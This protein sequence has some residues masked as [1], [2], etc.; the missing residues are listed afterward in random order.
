MNQLR[1]ALTILDEKCLVSSTQ[2]CART[3]IFNYR[4]SEFMQHTSPTQRVA[5]IVSQNYY[6]QYPRGSR[7]AVLRIEN[8]TL[9][10]KIAKIHFKNHEFDAAS[11]SIEQVEAFESNRSFLFLWCYSKYMVVSCL[12]DHG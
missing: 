6:E 7:I 12:C 9:E 2:W 5:E 4:L 10:Y 1:A 3:A 11:K 8:L